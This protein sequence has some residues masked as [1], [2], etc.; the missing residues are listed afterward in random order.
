[1]AASTSPL[2]QLEQQQSQ[3]QPSPQTQL[4]P[5]EQLEQAPQPTE[6]SQ[7]QDQPGFLQRAYETSPLPGI[8]DAVRGTYHDLADTP[9]KQADALHGTVDSIA[10]GDWRGA[11]NHAMSLLFGSENPFQD[12]AKSVIQSYVKQA[13]AKPADVAKEIPGASGLAKYVSDVRSGNTSGAIGDVVGTA[14]S[15]APMLLGDEATRTKASDAASAATDAVKSAASKVK[16]LVSEDAAAATAQPEVQGAIRDAAEQQ[17]NAL[18]AKEGVGPEAPPSVR[19]AVQNVADAV[20]ARSKAAFQT[21]DEASGGRWQRF[22]DA[23]SNLR[24]KIDE[25]AGVD[26]DAFEKYSQRAQDIEASQNDLVNQL[27]RDGKIDPDMAETA[28]NDY[29]QSQAL[30]DVSQQIRSS[31]SGL[32]PEIGE[33]TPETIDPAKLSPRLN[34]LYDSGRLQQAL[35][36]DGAAQLVKQVD[37]ALQTKAS[38]VKTAKLVKTVAKYGAVAGG[39]GSLYEGAKHILGGH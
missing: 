19:D 35:G 20:K 9:Q 30:Y 32:R 27:V 33:G 28:K 31:A 25:S 3:Q 36:P 14:S 2:D 22:D 24:D 17:S 16:P 10:A 23:L 18:R 29:R 11:A 26:D 13:A 37:Q 21:L 8:V 7:P 5:L 1:M 34:K 15:I 39:V 38:A 12:A 6:Q 4:S